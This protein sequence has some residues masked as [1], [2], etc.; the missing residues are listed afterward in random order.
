MEETGWS[1]E[2][3]RTSG[4]VYFYC[5]TSGETR[6]TCPSEAELECAPLAQR[7]CRGDRSLLPRR[8]ARGLPDGDPGPPRCAALRLWPRPATA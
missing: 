8:R 5:S 1:E 3:D 2:Y 4:K 7:S 6:W